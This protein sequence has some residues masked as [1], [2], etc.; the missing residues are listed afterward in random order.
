VSAGLGGQFA[1]DPAIARARSMAN[2]CVCD[3]PD[4]QFDLGLG[5]WC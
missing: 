3:N 5:D 2:A 4:T 1:A